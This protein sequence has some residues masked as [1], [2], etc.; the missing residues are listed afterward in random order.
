MLERIAGGKHSGLLRTLINFVFKKILT[1]YK[2]LATII[3]VCKRYQKGNQGKKLNVKVL[4]WLGFCPY[5]QTL[6]YG[7]AC[8]RQTL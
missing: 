8:Q 5:L 7:K 2:L 3:L 1:P 4:F 6:D